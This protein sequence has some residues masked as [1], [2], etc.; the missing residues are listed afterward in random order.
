MRP[1]AVSSTNLER[2]RGI[3]RVTDSARH[4][5]VTIPRCAALCCQNDEHDCRQGHNPQEAIAKLGAG[6]HIRRPVSG[7]NKAYRYE[8]AGANR[9]QYVEPSGVSGVARPKQASMQL[10]A[11][12]E[13]DDGV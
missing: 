8:Q 5:P 10:A 12:F 7:I 3:W 1:R 6:S 9:S 4:S 11:Y 13:V 2:K